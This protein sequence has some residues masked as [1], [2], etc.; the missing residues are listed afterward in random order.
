MA[1]FSSEAMVDRRQWYNMFNYRVE[2]SEL[3]APRS[4]PS[5]NTFRARVKNKAFRDKQKLIKFGTNQTAGQN[6]LKDDFQVEG[7]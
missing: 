3:P 1:N 7:S 6:M 2:N 4:A 5:N